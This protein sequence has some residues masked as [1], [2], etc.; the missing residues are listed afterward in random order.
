MRNER[1][2]GRKPC[3]TEEQMREILGCIER[4]ESVSILA[5]KYGVSR[6]ALYNRIR[7]N[8]SSRKIDFEYRVGD[9]V[10]TRI[11]AD[12]THEVVHIVN[13]AS[14]LS[15]C[16]FGVNMSPDWENLERLFEWEY[17]KSLGI[18][19]NT[20]G[21][22][23]VAQDVAT[24]SYNISDVIKHSATA[25]YTESDITGVP[26]F[27]LSKNDMLTARTDTDGY[28]MKAITRDRRWFV[29]SQ[30]IIGGVSMDDWAVELIASD[31]CRQLGIACVEQ[32]R[33]R[34]AY[35]GRNYEA[36]YSKNYELDGYTFVS[37]ERLLERQ[38][39]SSQ[40]EEFI[41]L[42]SIDKLK[43]CAERLAFAG[44]LP[45]DSTLRYM[46]DLALIDCL[47]GNVDR[48][49]K[50]FGLFYNVATS[51][52]EIPL[53]FD[54]GMGLFE[55]D[56]YKESYID[57]TEAMRNVYVSPYG[58][59]PFDMIELLDEEFEL[60]KMYPQL[61]ELKVHSEWMTEFASEYLERMLTRW[62][63]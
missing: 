26:A 7:Q 11:E 31:L 1:G 29:K 50:N 5:A 17:Y 2:A 60:E 16:A 45:Y 56:R 49:T 10:V 4:G 44:N 40:D 12:F 20:N 59:D 38:G 42:K 33:C 53:I 13:Y 37:F 25:I 14:K 39:L 3:I 30:A 57:F 24:D 19:E 36:V 23:F 27:N 43:W 51:E 55:H 54:N 9:A 52:Y 46:I 63:R 22:Q 21:T 18:A 35:A 28:Q 41:S 15:E 6:Q 47:V 61:R 62:Q 34:I 48:H 58:E 32:N 8:R